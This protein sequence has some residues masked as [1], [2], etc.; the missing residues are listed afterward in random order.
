ML[1]VADT[2]PLNYL[3]LT[4]H[5]NI[6]PQQHQRV[7]IPSAVRRELLSVSAPFTVRE[8]AGNLRIGWRKSIPPRRIWMILS[9]PPFT[10]G[11]ERLVAGCQPPADLPASG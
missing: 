5:I 1:V 9:W 10:T 6:L 8:W 3:V 4:E 2:S 7:L 11:S